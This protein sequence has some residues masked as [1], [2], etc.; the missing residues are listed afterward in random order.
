MLC[1]T[2]YLHLNELCD[3]VDGNEGHC[4]VSFNIC[5]AFPCDPCDAELLLCQLLGIVSTAVKAGVT[6]LLFRKVKVHLDRFLKY[7][8][9]SF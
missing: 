3:K 2:P 1:F 9:F 4:C 7:L 5:A 6:G 8:D